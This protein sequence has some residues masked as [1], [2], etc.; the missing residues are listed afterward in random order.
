MMDIVV[1]IGKD[2][3]FMTVGKIYEIN[4]TYKNYYY[5]KD[6]SGIMRYHIISEFITLDKYRNN[7]INELLSNI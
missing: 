2:T 5:I 3:L 7:K 1:F 6:D 4:D